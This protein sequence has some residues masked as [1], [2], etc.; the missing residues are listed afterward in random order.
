[1]TQSQLGFEPLVTIAE[2]ATAL[3]IHQLTLRGLCAKG[4]IPS[5]RVGGSVRIRPE[6]LRAIVFGKSA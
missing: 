5:V 3:G 6:V 4:E 1:M 2:A